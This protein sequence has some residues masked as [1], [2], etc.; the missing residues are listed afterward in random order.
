MIM[1]LERKLLVNQRF[2]IFKIW[3]NL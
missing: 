1:G 2:R 3:C